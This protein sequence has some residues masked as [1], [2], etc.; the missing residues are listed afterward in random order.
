MGSDFIE[1]DESVQFFLAQIVL[2]AARQSKEM[3]SVVYSMGPFQVSFHSN[4]WMGRIIYSGKGYLNGE[5]GTY[6]YG[7]ILASSN[8]PAGY[9]F[10][11]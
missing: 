11:G 2:F 8:P 10:D 3:G 1:T 9:I 7:N 5:T 6:P 4:P